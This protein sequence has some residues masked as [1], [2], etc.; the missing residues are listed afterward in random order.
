MVILD[1]KLTKS[2]IS[3]RTMLKKQFVKIMLSIIAALSHPPHCTLCTMHIFH[4]TSSTLHTVHCTMYQNCTAL[5]Y[6]AML[7]YNQS[8]QQD[9]LTASAVIKESTQITIY[10][11]FPDYWYGLLKWPAF[12]FCL[13]P[14]PFVGPFWEV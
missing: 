2:N 5:D 6:T 14:M 7:T 3:L 9:F 1:Q 10:F 8:Q 12:N 13:I 11:T 4:F